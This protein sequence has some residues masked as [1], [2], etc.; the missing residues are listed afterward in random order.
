MSVRDRFSIWYSCFY[1]YQYVVVRESFHIVN[2]HIFYYWNR[3]IY[4]TVHYVERFN[5]KKIHWV[6]SLQMYASIE[7]SSTTRNRL[8][9]ILQSLMHVNYIKVTKQYQQYLMSMESQS[10]SINSYSSRVQIHV[11]QQNI[12][13]HCKTSL[14]QYW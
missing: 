7:N 6:L 13:W 2:L 3:Y 11:L 5:L 8:E 4:F 12:K 9:S 14:F 10:A 1:I